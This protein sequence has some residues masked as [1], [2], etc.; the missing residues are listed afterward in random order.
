MFVSFVVV[1]AHALA[2][3]LAGGR[4]RVPVGGDPVTAVRRRIAQDTRCDVVEIRRSAADREEAPSVLHYDLTLR[5]C[6]A[7]PG[8]SRG[9]LYEGSIRVAI[10]LGVVP[11]SPPPRAVIPLRRNWEDPPA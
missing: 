7:G 3:G 2:K 6:L 11:R 9:T 8:V 4:V 5:G 10:G 1:G